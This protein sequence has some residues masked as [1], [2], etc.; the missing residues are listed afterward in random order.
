MLCDT[1][2]LVF[3]IVVNECGPRDRSKALEACNRQQAAGSK[4]MY[5]S[6]FIFAL[7]ISD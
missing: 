6:L 1:C 3:S 2:G 5:E 7:I 4:Q